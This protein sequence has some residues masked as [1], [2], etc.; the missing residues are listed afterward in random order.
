MGNLWIRRRWF[1]FRQGHAIYL[2]FLLTFANFVLIFY[3][4]L[5]EKIPILEEIFSNLWMFIV[6]FILIYIPIAILIGHWHNTTQL[7]IEI[8]RMVRENPFVARMW[9][10]IFEMQ[11]GKASEDEIKDVLNLLKSI[12]RGKASSPKDKDLKNNKEE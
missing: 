7:K 10:I 4:L 11:M 3:R 8:D 12:E 2:I 1:D 9:R 6:I 5:I